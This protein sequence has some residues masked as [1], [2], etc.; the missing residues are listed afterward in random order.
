M[1]DIKQK[2]TNTFTL[3]FFIFYCKKCNYILKNS[4]KVES[5]ACDEGLGA[6]AKITFPSGPI[7]IN[8]G[9]EFIPNAF[10]KSEFQ[11]L[12]ANN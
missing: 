8:L 2:N 12:S 1:E 6:S 4:P 5:K 3:V 9:I 7:K 11:L 10:I